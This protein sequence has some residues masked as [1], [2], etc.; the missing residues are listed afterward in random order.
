VQGRLHQSAEQSR[1]SKAV[2]VLVIEAGPF[3]QREDGIKVPGAWNPV[4]YVWPGLVT[5]PL[6][7]LNG[8]TPKVVTG[9]VVG[10]GTTINA[11]IILRCV[12]SLESVRIRLDTRLTLVQGDHS[13]LLCLGVSWK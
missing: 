8:L 12:P 7:A 10:G 1:H 3:D 13:G 11:M 6:T 5:E 2:T 4:S 9:K